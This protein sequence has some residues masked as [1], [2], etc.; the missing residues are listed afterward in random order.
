MYEICEQGHLCE[1]RR[2]TRCV[3]D[4]LND[5]SIRGSDQVR[6]AVAVD[7]AHGDPR[8]WK[9]ATHGHRVQDVREIGGIAWAEPAI[10]DSIIDEAKT[11]DVEL[12]IAIEV[13][14]HVV[15]RVHAELRV[16][17]AAEGSPG[18]SQGHPDVLAEI[19]DVQGS[20]VQHAVAVEV[21]HGRG[22]VTGEAGEEA[23]DVALTVTK[24]AVAVSQLD[25]AAYA[26]DE[27]VLLSIAVE[28]GDEHCRFRSEVAH[29]EGPVT[30]VEP[31]LDEGFFGNIRLSGISTERHG[32]IQLSV[33][34]EIRGDQ[35]TVAAE[36][37]SGDR[38]VAD[39]EVGV[40]ELLEGAVAV[41]VENAY[42][43]GAGA[44]EH[45]YV[46]LSVVIEIADCHE[47]GV[48]VGPNDPGV[49]KCAIAISQQN[50]DALTAEIGVD[51]VWGVSVG[52][53]DIQDSVAV[54]V[55]QRGHGRARDEVTDRV[56][57]LRD[58]PGRGEYLS[59]HPRRQG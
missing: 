55:R 5:P 19:R 58:M 50:A 9:R 21:T 32:Q 39:D 4:Y 12:P 11:G 52:G 57:E 26:V 17:G 45:R 14:G 59:G 20:H 56:Q 8:R 15:A 34:V 36:A 3:E 18:Q 35:G 27:K 29:A 7:I 10:A 6:R 49:L 41:A 25:R 2:T 53:D 33:A 42:R 13:G 43:V 22:Y 16:E 40:R 47:A 30:V 51:T 54:D 28:V 23:C 1:Q 44:I 37:S 38:G 46:G 31:N 24:R 48:P